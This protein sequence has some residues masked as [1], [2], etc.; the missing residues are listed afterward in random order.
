[1]QAP[2]RPRALFPSPAHTPSLPSSSSGT[3]LLSPQGNRHDLKMLLEFLQHLCPVVV[4]NPWGVGALSLL[5]LEVSGPFS[6][7]GC[8]SR[9]PPSLPRILPF[10]SSP[11][12]RKGEG[13]ICVLL[14][15]NTGPRTRPS[16]HG[17]S[18][19]CAEQTDVWWGTHSHPTIH[20]VAQVT[21]SLKNHLYQKDCTN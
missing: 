21:I 13:R 6:R 1:M 2:P 10:P 19:T 3:T 15:H 11:T 5:L 7:Q 9:K 20:T 17:C 14:N 12:V 8:P 16:L 4:M 18:V